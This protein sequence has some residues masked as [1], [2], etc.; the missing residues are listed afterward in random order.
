LPASP[1]FLLT[2]RHRLGRFEFRCLVTRHRHKISTL[3][4]LELDHN[5]LTRERRNIKGTFATVGTLHLCISHCE[6]Y[7]LETKLNNATPLIS[8]V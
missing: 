7:L 1:R 6:S 8:E 5:V 4:A 2:E 3:G